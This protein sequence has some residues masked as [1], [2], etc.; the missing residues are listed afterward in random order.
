[1]KA[2]E[3]ELL[4][5]AD[6][7]AQEMTDIVDAVAHH[8]KAVKPEAECET[9]PFFRIDVAVPEDIRM[10]QA[11]GEEFN[12]SALFAYAA[13]FSPAYEA[14]DVELETGLDKREE[15]RPQADFNVPAKN[16]PEEFLHYEYKVGDRYIPVD[17]HSFNL[18][19]C[20]F[21]RGVGRFVSE[22]TA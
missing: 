11:A 8:D 20:I 4:Q 15:S 14:V 5:K 9:G 13:A 1:M 10:H 17:H 19:E 3:L 16:F 21:M 22:Y 2:P 6:V 12:P 7:P 18:I